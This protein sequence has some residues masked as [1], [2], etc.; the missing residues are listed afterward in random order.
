MSDFNLSKHPDVLAGLFFMAVGAFFLWL[1]SDYGFGSMMRMGAG[2]FPVILSSLIILVGAV[3]AARGF[4]EASQD[5][6]S[7]SVGPTVRVLGAVAIF[8]ALIQPLGTYLTIPL[9]VIVA[10]S[11]SSKFDIKSTVALAAGMAVSVDVILRV[12]LGLPL[13]AL[14][15]WMGG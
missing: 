1:G 8:A 12:G 6:F 2:F 4:V 15:S 7:I 10:A 11:A 14:G 5:G 3:I 13:S 9:V